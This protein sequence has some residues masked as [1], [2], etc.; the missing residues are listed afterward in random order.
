MIAPRRWGGEGGGGLID[1]AAISIRGER[2]PLNLSDRWGSSVLFNLSE[3][4]HDAAVIP[5]LMAARQTQQRSRRSLGLSVSSFYPSCLSLNFF[6]SAGLLV[7]S[8]G[9][10][11]RRLYIPQSI[12]Q[13]FCLSLFVSLC[14]SLSLYLYLCL[15]VYMYVSDCLSIMSIF[16]LSLY[17]QQNS[18]ISSIYIFR[19]LWLHI[20]YVCNTCAPVEPF[21]ITYFFCS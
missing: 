12:S 13:F 4:C 1:G 6:W 15:Y 11:G 17:L 19:F 14:I 16:V 5:M 9:I 10:S 20:Q 3:R 2:N 18:S 7:L 8:V 21:Q